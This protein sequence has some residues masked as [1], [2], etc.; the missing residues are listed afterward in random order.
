MFSMLLAVVVAAGMVA[1]PTATP[2]PSPRSIGPQTCF[3]A[4]GA[5]RPVAPHIVC[6]AEVNAC[7]APSAHAVFAQPTAN[8]HP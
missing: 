5:C 1:A 2:S 6:F 8:P 3:A 7:A 4:E